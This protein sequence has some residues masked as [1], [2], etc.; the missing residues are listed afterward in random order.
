MKDILDGLEAIESTYGVRILF[1]VESGSR[2]WGF[3]SPNS[4]FDVRFIYVNAPAYYLSINDRADCIDNTPFNTE[5][6]DFSGWC[7][8][9]SMQLFK[10]SNPSLFEWFGSPVIYISP[11]DTIKRLIEIRRTFFNPQSAMYHYLHMA[12]GN[13]KQ[14]LKNDMVR[15][16]K[17][18]YVLRPLLAC[19]FIM[20]YHYDPPI[21]F[22]ILMEHYLKHEDF[23]LAEVLKLLELK[24]SGAEL[25]MAAQIPTVNAWIEKAIAFYEQKASR[26]PT[27][28]ADLG[29]LNYLFC[30]SVLRQRI[31]S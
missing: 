14:Y 20:R 2:V 15:V 13:Y 16:K 10:K 25:G 30:N 17:Y 24:R 28:Q 6:Y 7:L 11:D 26:M 21:D 4:D 3:H 5:I 9:K 23:P 22:E 12:I 19:D 31:S 8:R 27:K 1:A 29:E 18:F